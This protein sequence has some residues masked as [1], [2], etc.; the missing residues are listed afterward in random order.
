MSV[1]ISEVPIESVS[2]PKMVVEPVYED[3]SKND[4]DNVSGMDDK[5]IFENT[6]NT[7]TKENNDQIKN[8]E[9]KKDGEYPNENKKNE[10]DPQA[11]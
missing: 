2:L 10:A 3:T 8:H 9:N 4:N 11:Q 7:E 5:Q 1:E 6:E